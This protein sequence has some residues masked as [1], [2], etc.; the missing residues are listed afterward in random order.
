M[1]ARLFRTFFVL[2]VVLGSVLASRPA[3]AEEIILKIATVA[4]KDTPW[5]MLLREYKKA[6]EAKTGGRVKVKLYLGKDLGPN[7]GPTVIDLEP[8]PGLLTG[9]YVG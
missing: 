9:I 3:S 1:L 7:G 4:P 2:S 5:D 6:V 8:Y